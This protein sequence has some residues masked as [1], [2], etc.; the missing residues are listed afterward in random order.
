MR[1]WQEF[2]NGTVLGPA[3]A[4]TGGHHESAPQQGPPVAVGV[5]ANRKTEDR[6]AP[7]NP[8]GRRNQLAG[9][10]SRKRPVRSIPSTGS[11]APS[12]T[13]SRPP[14]R[15]ARAASPSLTSRSSPGA[16]G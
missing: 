8:R 13:T 7:A 3:V 10:A 15:T 6:R 9:F 4:A 5:G 2:T 14:I 11:G 12:R 16:P 1:T